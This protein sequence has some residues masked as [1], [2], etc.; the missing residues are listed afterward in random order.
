MNKIPNISK[1]YDFAF[2]CG[3]F[4]IIHP[5]YINLFQE[6]HAFAEKVIVGLNTS[7]ETKLPSIFSISDRIKLL[8]SIVYID[9]VIPYTGEN[10]LECLLHELSSE[11]IIRIVGDDYLEKDSFTGKDILPIYYRNTRGEWRYSQVLKYIKD[12]K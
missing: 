7:P 12:F 8:K 11:K 5:G 10:A 4:D 3:Q 6:C 2:T 9:Y 1:Q